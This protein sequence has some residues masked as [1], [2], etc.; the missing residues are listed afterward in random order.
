MTKSCFFFAILLLGQISLR[1]EKTSI[2]TYPLALVCMVQNLLLG[3][4]LEKSF[5]TLTF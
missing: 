1:N 4:E 3:L 2:R 5:K